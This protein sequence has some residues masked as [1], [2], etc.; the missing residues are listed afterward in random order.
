MTYT[1]DLISQ[2]DQQKILKDFAQDNNKDRYLTM[3]GG[4]FNNNPD[5][6]WAIDRE[7]DSYLLLSPTIGEPGNTYYF[8]YLDN[9]V[10]SIFFKGALDEV[11]KFRDKI[12]ASKIEDEIFQNRIKEAFLVYGRFGH[13]DKEGNP[14]QKI[15]AQFEKRK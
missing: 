1:L 14:L 10:Y 6:N 11:I 8:F 2:K 15:S 5:L 13:G 3:R 12:D 7:N 9:I 4:H